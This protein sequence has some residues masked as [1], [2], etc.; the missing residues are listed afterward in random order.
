LYS[1]SVIAPE[2]SDG[3]EVWGQAT[4]QPH[5]LDVALCFSLE[6]AT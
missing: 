4:G 6:P 3:L 1:W 2:I 5:Q